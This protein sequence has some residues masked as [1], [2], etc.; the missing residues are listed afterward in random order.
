MPSKTLTR[1][2]AFVATLGALTLATT[3]SAQ[4]YGDARVGFD[5]G[6]HIRQAVIE[7]GNLILAGATEA[8]DVFVVLDDNVTVRSNWTDGGF[9]LRLA[10][11]QPDVNCMVS[12]Q[13]LGLPI[14]V[15]VSGCTPA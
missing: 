7:N 3:S 1:I 8:T 2:A 11:Y 4:L 13:S 9:Y 14:S 15:L 10:N 6:L 5:Q 12:V